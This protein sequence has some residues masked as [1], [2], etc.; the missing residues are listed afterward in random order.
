[1]SN[2]N[3]NNTNNT[4]M[5]INDPVKVDD[6]HYTI[7]SDKGRAIYDL[8][9]GEH[10]WEC[11]CYDFCRRYECKHVN[12][13][14]STLESNERVKAAIARSGLTLEAAFDYSSR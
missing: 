3:G 13:L 1:M 11:T 12:K 8:Y 2:N 5:A 7:K 6:Y 9:L 10:I 4:K 14:L